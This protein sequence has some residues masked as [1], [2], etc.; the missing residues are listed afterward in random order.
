MACADGF[1]RWMWPILAAY[2][3]DYPEQCLVA[4]CMENRCPI[5][6]VHPTNRG[7][8]QP[9]DPRKRPE[10]LTLLAL[11]EKGSLSMPE[12]KNFK[13]TYENTGLR[14]IYPPF[15][16][17][18]PFCDIFQSFTPDLLHQLHK[19]VFKD[20][21]VKWCT[22]LAGAK[23]IDG[24]FRSMTE[25]I[26]LRHFKN[27]ISSVSQWTG[28]EHKAMERV[29]VGLVSGAIQERAVVDFIFYS[30]LQSHTQ[31][32]LQAL[33]DA[34]DAFHE[35]KDVFIELEARVPAHFNIPK[36]HSMMHYV[37]LIRMFGSADGFNT[38][39]PERL[40][41]DYAKNAYRASNKKDYTV[42]MT[43]WLDRQESI[44][45]FTQY[46]KWF[47]GGNYA[48]SSFN[49]H[50]S[51]QLL[52]EDEGTL[53]ATPVNH[54]KNSPLPPKPTLRLSYSLATR[55]PP[56]LRGIPACTITA[57]HNAAWFLPAIQNFLDARNSRIKAM[58]FDGF[59]LFKRVRLM[60]PCIPEA[61]PTDLVNIVR[62]TPP[63]PACHRS[64]AE[65]PHLD[66]ALIRTGESNV[67]TDGTALEGK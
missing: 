60:L 59:D 6:K 56:T 39:S 37:W 58:P 34:L 18:L 9:S 50:P 8:N 16:T 66:F 43:R 51:E 4:C 55:H 27:G 35:Y 33:Q 67:R 38:E 17:A 47:K 32:S 40:H 45:R 5:C 15:W 63:V 3:A 57:N 1:V 24:R 21:L 41:I 2:V 48:P 14:P 13:E 19:G 61:S 62:A 54:L 53:V 28:S 25:Y 44:H 36:I 49:L 64:P 31:K 11:K 52:V 42:Q 22:N 10:T 30:S 12:M 23:E 29:F 46:S 7:A 65:P 20:H 26:G